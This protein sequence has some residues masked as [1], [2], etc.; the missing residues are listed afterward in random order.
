MRKLL[1]VV[2]AVAL[3]S[4]AMATPANAHMIQVTNPQT[5]ETV[6]THNG[7]TFEE[8]KAWAAMNGF[9]D[10]GWVGGGGAA[11][12]H[13]LVSACE[14]TA[15]NDVVSISAPWNELNPCKHGGS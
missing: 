10:V 12:G 13:G 2:P 7:K 8:F 9:G 14:A 4:V 6:S 3:A 5:G 1:V 15:D 11:H